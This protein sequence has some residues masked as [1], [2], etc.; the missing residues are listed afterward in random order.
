MTCIYMYTH[1]YT[2]DKV[3]FVCFVRGSY[4]YIYIT[5]VSAFAVG[6]CWLASVYFAAWNIIHRVRHVRNASQAADGR[7]PPPVLC[8]SLWLEAGFASQNDLQ[9]GGP[10]PG[11]SPTCKPAQWRRPATC[12]QGAQRQHRLSAVLRLHAGMSDATSRTHARRQIRMQNS[13]LWQDLGHTDSML[14]PCT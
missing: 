13:E 11:I 8:A 14:L 9:C 1:I 3:V 2:P 7:R 6:T 5:C 10:A 12:L 4:I